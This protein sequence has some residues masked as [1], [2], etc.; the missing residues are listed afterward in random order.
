MHDCI[1]HDKMN[2]CRY[3]FLL[4]LCANLVEYLCFSLFVIASNQ[5]YCVSGYEYKGH[6]NCNKIDIGGHKPGEIL[7]NMDF[8]YGCNYL[9]YHSI[10][11]SKHGKHNAVS[12]HEYYLSKFKFFLCV[13]P[14]FILQFLV[15]SQSCCSVPNNAPFFLGKI[16]VLSLIPCFQF[17]HFFP[18]AW[19]RIQPVTML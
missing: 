17:M 11:L 1:Y 14:C 13:R 7:P 16:M 10:K 12:S 6:R 18:K 2:K 5:F 3:A 9:Y 19:K 8:C 4:F 15:Y